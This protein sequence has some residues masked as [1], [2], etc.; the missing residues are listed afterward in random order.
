CIM[1]MIVAIAL[2]A[3]TFVVVTRRVIGPLLAMTD[4]VQHLANG[5]K[6]VAV[7]ASDRDDEIGR[8][9]TAVQVFKQNLVE[10]GELQAEQPRE[11]AGKARGARLDQLIRGF[12]TTVGG[13][14]ESLAAAAAEMDATAQSMAGTA[15]QTHRQA[16]AVASSA[17]QTSANVQTVA[18]ATEELGASIGE[19]GRQAIDSSRMSKT[20][21]Q[22]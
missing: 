15:E 4:A 5:D 13:F 19:I 20:A 6:T 10:N 21:V 22:A 18:A 8:M 3:G 12:E 1:L 2:S 17:E 9:A 14:V 7:P 16:I 11:T